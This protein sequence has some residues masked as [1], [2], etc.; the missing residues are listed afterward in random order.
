MSPF[1]IGIGLVGLYF[2]CRTLVAD[3]GFA[4]CFGHDLY[5]AVNRRKKNEVETT[6]VVKGK[7]DLYREKVLRGNR[8][9]ESRRRGRRTDRSRK[10]KKKKNWNK[11]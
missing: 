1:G 4:C 3:V 6:T 10:K 11:E 9:T 7:E 5:L 8:M 2:Y